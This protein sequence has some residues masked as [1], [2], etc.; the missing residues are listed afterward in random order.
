[1]TCRVRRALAAVLVA[2]CATLARAQDVPLFT[3]DFP[4]EEFAQ[5]RAAVYEAIGD[6]VAVVQGAPSPAGYMRFRQSNEFYYLCGIE[7]PN[8]YLLLDGRRRKATLYLPHRNER[9]EKGEGK[10][11]SARGRR[12]GAEALGRRPGLRRRP[13]RRASRPLHPQREGG[14][15]LHASRPRRGRLDEPGPRPPG[16]APTAGTDPWDGRPSREGRFR[17]LLLGALPGPR[18]ARPLAHARRAAPD[19]EPAGDGADHARR[20]A[21]PRSRSWRAMRS[22]VPGLLEHELDARGQVHL[23]PARRPG[24]GL[25]LADRQRHE[26]VVP[27]LQRRQAPHEGWRAAADGLRPRRGLLHERHHAAVAGERTLQPV[28]SGSCTASTSA[29]YRKIL[30]AIRP[31]N[32]RRDGRGRSGRRA[33][34]RCSPPRNSRSRSTR[35]PRAVS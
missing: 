28:R 18:G 6:S 11:L 10:L 19:Q 32:D 15:V 34:T 35:R 3:S 29:C 5:R 21:W 25:L 31:G 1:M 9:R 23:L 30:E 24:R 26:R 20:H 22:T 12:P 2:S 14:S 4:P 17:E 8:A 7:V 13:A 16:R 33:W 27:A